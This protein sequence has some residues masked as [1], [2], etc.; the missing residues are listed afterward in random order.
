M[1]KK[2]ETIKVK[3]QEVKT[4]KEKF[5]AAFNQSGTILKAR[6]EMLLGL[7]TGAVS[8]ID[9]SPLLGFGKDVT[10]M[11]WKAGLGVASYMFLTGLTAEITR[12][13][14]TRTLP[15]GKLVPK[16]N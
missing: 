16:A 8:M 6:L 4:F 7:V 3:V 13:R 12:R 14:G 9:W 11:S 15:D 2:I 1:T 5:W 10:E